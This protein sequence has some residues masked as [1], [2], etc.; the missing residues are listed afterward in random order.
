[1]AP[2][3]Q[4]KMDAVTGATNTLAGVFGKIVEVQF[5]CSDGVS[6]GTVA[7]AYVPLDGL[8]AAVNISTGTVAGVKI[9]RPTVDSTDIA[10]VDLT[11]DSPGCFYISGETLRLIVA[12]S[13]TN[14]TWRATIKVDK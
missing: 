9:F 14:K 13:P 2:V 3:L 1:M 8:N 12:G 5:S 10:G 6:T 4:V 7:L 11:S